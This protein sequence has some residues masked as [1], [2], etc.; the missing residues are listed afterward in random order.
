MRTW[1]CRRT[2]HHLA[3]PEAGATR[4][5]REIHGVSVA[6][7]TETPWIYYAMPERCEPGGEAS[8]QERKPV[9]TSSVM[10]SSTLSESPVESSTTTRPTPRTL[11]R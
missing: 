6:I 1:P 8:S 7:T 5:F 11:R 3:L 4:Y 2:A 10:A 9:S